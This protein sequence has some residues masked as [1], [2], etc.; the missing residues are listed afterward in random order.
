MLLS[1]NLVHSPRVLHCWSSTLNTLKFP[2]L[3]FKFA[4]SKLEGSPPI[5]WEDFGSTMKYP[6]SL[7]FG[8]TWL[9]VISHALSWF[10][11]IQTSQTLG[12]RCQS[13]AT[14][15]ADDDLKLLAQHIHAEASGT[16][17]MEYHAG[18]FEQKV[19]EA[20]ISWYSRTL[21]YSWCAFH[22]PG[23]TTL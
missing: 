22:G 23:C 16:L 7:D 2:K 20:H 10:L 9:H 3:V 1:L 13:N 11:K 14:A 5:L 19:K 17:Q 6:R 21:R 12:C 8:C 4:S 15:N 18:M